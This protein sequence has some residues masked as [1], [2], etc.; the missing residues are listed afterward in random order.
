MVDE[1]LEN[2]KGK[3]PYIIAGIAAGY[4]LKNLID[5]LERANLLWDIEQDSDITE[6]EII[7]IKAKTE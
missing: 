2:L 3:V 1:I 5:N 6:D 4:F 7:D